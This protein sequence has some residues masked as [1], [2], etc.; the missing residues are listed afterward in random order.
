MET[1]GWL[2]SSAAAAEPPGAHASDRG[3]ATS[4]TFYQ[5]MT[6]QKYLQ[7]HPNRNGTNGTS[8]GRSI[9]HIC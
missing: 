9:Q 1:S 6:S 8:L 2:I 4:R 3:V 5:K 7:D